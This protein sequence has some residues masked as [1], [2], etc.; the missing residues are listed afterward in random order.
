M[1]ASHTKTATDF[2]HHFTIYRKLKHRLVQVRVL[3]TIPQMH[4]IHLQGNI[5]A[6]AFYYNISFC[7]QNADKHLCILCIVPAL[8]IYDGIFAFHL[9]RNLQP[10]SAKI[11]QIKMIFIY[12]NHMNITINTTIKRKIRF[13]RIYPVIDAIIHNNLQMIV[14][15]Q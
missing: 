5:R 14:R 10:R 2:I 4:L 6:T 11:I 8:D 12:Y 7:V 1:E 15:L 13:L 3:Q 9:W